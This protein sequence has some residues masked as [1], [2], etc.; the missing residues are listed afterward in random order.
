MI[1]IEVSNKQMYIFEKGGSLDTNPEEISEEPIGFLVS[2]VLAT[3]VVKGFGT[4]LS[5]LVV[6]LT[7][8]SWVDRQYLDAVIKFIRVNY[9]ETE[10]SWKET[11][12]YLDSM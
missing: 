8:Y 7:G 4:K 9:P 10:I 1:K 3:T 5:K 2:D 12:E 11:F 6:E